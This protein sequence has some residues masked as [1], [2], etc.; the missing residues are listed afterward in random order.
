MIF[1]NGFTLAL[2]ALKRKQTLNNNN[3]TFLPYWMDNT[4]TN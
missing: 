3:I 2:L 1:I 4:K